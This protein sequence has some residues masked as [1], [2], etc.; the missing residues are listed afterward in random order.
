MKHLRLWPRSLSGQIALDAGGKVVGAGDIK[1]QARQ[2]F[3]NIES[4]LARCGGR[5]SDIVWELNPAC[6]TLASFGHYLAA[7][8]ERW[9]QLTGTRFKVEIPPDLPALAMSALARRYLAMV[10]QEALNNVAKHAGATETKLLLR[11]GPDE[12]FLSVQDNGKGFDPAANEATPAGASRNGLRNQKSRLRSATTS[13]AAAGERTAK[14]RAFS[15]ASVSRLPNTQRSL[16]AN[17]STASSS[18]VTT[19]GIPTCP[20]A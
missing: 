17:W 13:A 15:A 10:I 7:H 14:P 3:S 16:P 2:C 11:I 12:L 5:M 6:D 8:A 18:S 20:P 19:A 4:I 9:A 1:V